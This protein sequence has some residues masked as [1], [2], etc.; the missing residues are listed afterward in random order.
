MYKT[1]DLTEKDLEQ[2]EIK[3]QAEIVQY[4][5][6]ELNPKE[7]FALIKKESKD[8]T[9]PNV[10]AEQADALLYAIYKGEAT[11]VTTVEPEIVNAWKPIPKHQALTTFEAGDKVYALGIDNQKV[12]V[13]SKDVFDFTDTFFIKVD[14]E[15]SKEKTTLTNEQVKIL[16]LKKEKELALLSIRLK[17]EKNNKTAA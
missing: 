12:R 8:F 13:Q 5:G 10:K 7:A 15:E 6:S 14:T 2:I 11:V 4:I 17:R 16:K 3:N 1:K 9:Q